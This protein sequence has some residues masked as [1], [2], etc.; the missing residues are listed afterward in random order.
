MSRISIVV[1]TLNEEKNIKNALG[2]VLWADEI[3]VCDNYSSDKTVEIA[4][5]M[6]AKVYKF[7]GR[8]Y[9]E[10]ARNFAI[11]KASGDWILILDADELITSLLA[12][13]L[14][15]VANSDSEVDF[16]KIPR[17]NIIYG[18]FMKA[19]FWWPDYQ[20]RFFKKG[21]VKWSNKIH[22]QPITDG[23]GVDLPAQENY[24]ILHNNYV[25]VSDYLERMISY[26]KIQADELIDDGYKFNWQ[27]L[28]KKPLS[29]FLSRFF[30]NKGYKD[31]LHGLALSLLQAFSFIIVYIRVWEKSGFSEKILNKEDIK[32]I[33]DESGKEINYWL[34]NSETSK[35][36]FRKLFGK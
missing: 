17:K 30:A 8:G 12:E 15:K 20:I 24:A 10:P 32:K 21:K 29:E 35:N 5:E 1:N 25:G 36:P 22:S 3:I 4:K 33:F 9:V 13:E 27:D 11:S 26:S 2:S 6:G 19:S 18:K 16:V 31:G 28:I 7:K 23:A 34:N 14:K